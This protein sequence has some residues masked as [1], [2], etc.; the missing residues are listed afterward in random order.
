MPSY[1]LWLFCS[2]VVVGTL[3]SFGSSL[4][5]N[6][7]Q[8]QQQQDQER[9]SELRSVGMGS[10]LRDS[11]TIEQDRTRAFDKLASAAAAAA[12]AADSPET[13]AGAPHA[14]SV[15]HIVIVSGDREDGPSEEVSVTTRETIPLVKSILWHASCPLDFTFITGGGSDEVLRQFF[16][17]IQSPKHRV[18]FAAINLNTHSI[19]K[20]AREM[21][22]TYKHHSAVWGLSKF[23]LAED[24]YPRV[25]GALVI[26][27]DFIFAADIC[28]LWA[29]GVQNVFLPGK[30]H[31]SSVPRIG[32]N[33]KN[34]CSCLS[35]L[36]FEVMIREGWAGSLGK[37]AF[38]KYL[39][40]TKQGSPIVEGDQQMNV[41]IAQHRPDLF[42]TVPRSWALN[43]CQFLFGL[44]L[45]PF[46][47]DIP[48]ERNSSGLLQILKV[49]PSSNNEQLQSILDEEP[50]YRP[51]KS[52]T[53]SPEQQL[54]R[55]T[56]L[57]ERRKAKAE[58]HLFLGAIHYNCPWHKPTKLKWEIFRDVVKLYK[59]EWLS[60]NRKTPNCFETVWNTTDPI[61]IST[62]AFL[63]QQ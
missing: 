9:E 6:P 54:Q 61:A 55:P 18:T 1:S 36:N 39:P 46:V 26:D 48:N 30:M 28:D 62:D 56:S 47:E 5:F 52:A 25:S 16:R 3:L 15:P 57:W 24:L 33:N 13:L 29:W 38:R 43:L 41:A 50:K 53:R 32:K 31:A 35:F 60:G 17:R 58:K 7:Q 11:S 27:T 14:F 34:L 2:G 59:P 10:M 37:T 8:Q 22:I 42:V 49:T 40:A 21:N 45:E 19:H 63:K 23:F 44:D 20:R 4:F 12:A 51:N